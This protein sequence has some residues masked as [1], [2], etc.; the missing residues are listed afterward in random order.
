MHRVVASWFGTGLILGRIRGNDLGSGTVGALFALPVA[1]LV[2]EWWGVPGQV[3][4]AAI[5]VLAA[6][7]SA[8]PFVRGEGDAGWICVDEAAGAFI[9]VIGLPAGPYA[10]VAWVVFRAADIYK[11]FAPGVAAAERIPGA[12]GVTADD[13][14]AGLY[15][16]VA[17]H[18]LLILL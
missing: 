10:I 2:G 7:W 6:L 16:L 11:N 15:G 17:G 8:A 14:V 4:A 9:A 3:I 13:V 5:V 1:L 12:V 18:V